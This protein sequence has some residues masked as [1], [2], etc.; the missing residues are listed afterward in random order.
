M[1]EFVTNLL[2]NCVMES[3]ND[4]K[5]IMFD[6]GG[7]I[8]SRGVHWSEV[9]WQGYR[10]AEI[11]VD[12]TVFRDAYVYAERLLA[13]EPL[14][15]SDFTFCDLM[16]VKVTHELLYLVRENAFPEELVEAKAVEV[17]EYCDKCARECADEARPVLEY[18]Q[19][20]CPMVMVSNFYGNLNAVL[21]EYDLQRYFNQVV[22]SAV[23]GVRK[24]DSRIFSLGVEAL[25]MNPENVLV[26]GD[27]YSKDIEP[28][29]SL[30]CKAVWL[31]GVGWGDTPENKYGVKV[32]DSLSELTTT[33]F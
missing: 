12:K 6:Y 27:S 28:A 23:V 26:V 19:K 25:G 1:R 30:G 16:L 32:I 33:E 14:I 8:D 24:P 5:G 11:E 31:Q 15:K 4:I 18:L 2:A 22:E 10:N 29:I 21:K 7:T 17:A 3:I 13:K 9:I 20:H